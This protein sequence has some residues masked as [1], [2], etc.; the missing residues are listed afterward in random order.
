MGYNN[1]NFM[2]SEIVHYAICQLQTNFKEATVHAFIENRCKRKTTLYQ[3]NY[4]K[5]ASQEFHPSPIIVLII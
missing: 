3:C 4:D 1:K 2:A 5:E